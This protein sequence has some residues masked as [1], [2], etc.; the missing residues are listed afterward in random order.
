VPVARQAGPTGLLPTYEGLC[1]TK[2]LV[3]SGVSDGCQSPEKEVLTRLL[4]SG[5]PYIYWLH[6]LPEPTATFTQ[7]EVQFGNWLPRADTLDEFPILFR[8]Q[9]SSGNGFAGY[10]TLLWD[11]PQFNPFS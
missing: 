6:E 9:R 1:Y 3:Q 2:F 11:D 4:R 5:V 7:I 8:E 10:A